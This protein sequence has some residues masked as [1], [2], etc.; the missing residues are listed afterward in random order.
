MG[1]IRYNFIIKQKNK[2]NWIKNI[3]VILAA[4]S[5]HRVGSH[6][7]KQFINLAGKPIKDV[8]S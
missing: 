6:F 5:R 3:A 1:W 7:P 2:G 4:R 8:L